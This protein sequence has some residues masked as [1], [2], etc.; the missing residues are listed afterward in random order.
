MARYNLYSLKAVS[1][2]NT[3]Y[4]CANGWHLY[5][6]CMSHCRKKTHFHFQSFNK[7]ITQ[8]LQE[9]CHNPHW[10]RV[11]RSIMIGC[12]PSQTESM[13]RSIFHKLGTLSK[14]EVDPPVVYQME[15]TQVFDRKD[16]ID[17]RSPEAGTLAAREEDDQYA[18]GKKVQLVI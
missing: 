15:M 16:P 12:K 1:N 3:L 6:F 4:H 18:H 11:R 7:F 5:S 17:L 9:I 10:M 14:H 2:I 8:I 13:Y